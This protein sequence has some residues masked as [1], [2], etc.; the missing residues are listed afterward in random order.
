MAFAK[1]P[2]TSSYEV[3]SADATFT[4]Q[5][6]S[7]GVAE[8]LFAAAPP[9]PTDDGLLIPPYAG[10]DQDMGTGTLYGRN[11]D[12]DRIVVFVVST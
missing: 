7:S 1:V 5:N 8:V 10:V 3:I 11:L 12:A 6:I 4:A 2:L 9:A